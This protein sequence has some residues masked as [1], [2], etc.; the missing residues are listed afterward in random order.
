G[1]TLVVETT[2]FNN[3]TNFLFS[4]TVGPLENLRL[5]ERFTRVGPDTL[6]YEVTLTD[7]TT[8]TKPWSA[9]LFWTRSNEEIYEYACHEGNE[10][11]A[12]ALSGTR[13]KEGEAQAA[14][15][16]TKGSK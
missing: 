4:K 14:T 6:Q 1:D 12:G 10:G 9:T 7:P 2:N 16:T 11:L 8:W 5:V 15:A 13:A 3:R